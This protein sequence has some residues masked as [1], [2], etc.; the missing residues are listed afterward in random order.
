M[1][2]SWLSSGNVVY[3]SVNPGKPTSSLI[4]ARSR[5][6]QMQT[7]MVLFALLTQT[8]TR[9]LFQPPVFSSPTCLITAWVTCSGH[10]LTRT[11][12]MFIRC[13]TRRGGSCIAENLPRGRT[14]MA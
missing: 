14:E 13:P 7:L 4:T 3:V 9:A 5:L 1:C 11:L 10:N 6:H 8:E 2:R 12:G